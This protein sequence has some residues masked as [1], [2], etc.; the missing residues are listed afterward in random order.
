VVLSPGFPVAGAPR[1]AGYCAEAA[2]R[3]LARV[4]PPRDYAEVSDHCP[5]VIGE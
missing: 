3:P 4:P 5:V 1:V 2:C